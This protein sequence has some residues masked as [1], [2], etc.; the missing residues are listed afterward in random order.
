ML[1][2]RN[3]AEF[4]SLRKEILIYL[5]RDD[6]CISLLVQGL[7]I[8]VD[9]FLKITLQNLVVVKKCKSVSK[10]AKNQMEKTLLS[11]HK[12]AVQLH[13]EPSIQF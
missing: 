1:A 13:H 2:I 3:N 6:N 5:V 8:T 12:S 4:F 10:G 9:V 11:L 7:G